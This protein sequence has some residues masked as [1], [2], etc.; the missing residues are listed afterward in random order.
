MSDIEK[1]ANDCASRIMDRMEMCRGSAILKDDIA[2]EVE[3]ALRELKHLDFKEL[4]ETPHDRGIPP[5]TEDKKLRS[6]GSAAKQDFRLLG[7]VVPT[8]VIERFVENHVESANAEATA[9]ATKYAEEL[10]VLINRDKASIAKY[11]ELKRHMD[12]NNIDILSQE[13]FLR[14]YFGEEYDALEAQ[15]QE[16]VER[17]RATYWS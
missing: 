12:L 1:I 10:G 13:A 6:F 3:S 16:K 8:S 2:R 7:D 17:W 15:R 14:G 5:W 4:T 9:K 11:Q